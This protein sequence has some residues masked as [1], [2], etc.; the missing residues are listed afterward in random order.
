[1]VYP[2][3]HDRFQRV[4]TNAIHGVNIANEMCIFI[5]NEQSKIVIKNSG[6]VAIQDWLKRHLFVCMHSLWSVC[7]VNRV[8]ICPVVAVYCVVIFDCLL[9]KFGGRIC[10]YCIMLIIWLYCF[11]RLHR[12]DSYALCS[13]SNSWFYDIDTFILNR[14]TNK[15][16]DCCRFDTILYDFIRYSKNKCDNSNK[17][18]CF[19]CLK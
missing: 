8:S 12:Y 3:C 14:E 19:F 5:V 10:V 16:V 1:M 17:R 2:V 6:K 11:H 9:S 18:L 7:F 4:K 15:C 13:I